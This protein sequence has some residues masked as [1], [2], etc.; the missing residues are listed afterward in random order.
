MPISTKN[1]EEKN[2]IAEQKAIRKIILEEYVKPFV[3]AKT[4]LSFNLRIQQMEFNGEYFTKISCCNG[5]VKIKSN[6]FVVFKLKDPDKRHVNYA[7]HYIKYS[8]DQLF[9]EQKSIL[10]PIYLGKID[11]ENLK[12]FLCMRYHR[13]NYY[14]K[15]HGYLM[16]A[17]AKNLPEDIRSIAYQSG[18]VFFKGRDYFKQSILNLNQLVKHANIFDIVQKDDKRLTHLACTLLPVVDAEFPILDNSTQ[19]TVP[20]VCHPIFPIDLFYQSDQVIYKIKQSFMRFGL[21][22]AGWRCY[23]K[24][25]VIERQSINRLLVHSSTLDGVD[26][27]A[28]EI[29]DKQAWIKRYVFPM[30]FLNIKAELGIKMPLYD[31]YPLLHIIPDF[32]YIELQDFEKEKYVAFLKQYIT[33]VLMYLSKIKKEKKLK[34]AGIIDEIRNL[35]PIR[36]WLDDLNTPPVL[37][38]HAGLKYLQKQTDDWHKEILLRELEESKISWLPGLQKK[39]PTIDLF[40]PD[41]FNKEEGNLRFTA[42]LLTN[43]LDFETESQL[44]HHC[45]KS[46]YEIAK[47]LHAEIFHLEK[48]K[49]NELIEHATLDLRCNNEPHEKELLEVYECRSIF[50]KQISPEMEDFACYIKNIMCE[51]HFSNKAKD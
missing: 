8:I 46:R 39:Y 6:G 26:L 19:V 30:L 9:K 32:R 38:R 21:S 22:N 35:Y 27:H 51:N 48:W 2:K 43:S 20:Q 29:E 33:I 15:A 16:Q 1:N 5:W 23:L 13:F 40:L 10:E 25:N 50:N 12:T 49:N 36:D 45:I 37:P 47:R 31:F 41:A 18:M 7:F 11:V 24:L 14:N 3:K 17:I 42:R 44:M 34:N 4:S 28:N